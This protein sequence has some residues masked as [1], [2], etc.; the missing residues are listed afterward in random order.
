[1][2]LRSLSAALAAALLGLPPLPLLA[3]DAAPAA[4][5]AVT[6]SGEA[7]MP[8]LRDARL[9]DKFTVALADSQVVSTFTLG[10]NAAS[11]ALGGLI[12][13]DEGC[14]LTGTGSIVNPQDASQRLTRTQYSGGFEVAPDG[15]ADLSKVLLTYQSKSWFMALTATCGDQVYPLQG[16]MPWSEVPGGKDRTQCGP[17]SGLETWLAADVQ[18]CIR[19]TDRCRAAL[20]RGT[21]GGYSADTRQTHARAAC[22]LRAA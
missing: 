5:A 13:T 16:Q 9:H 1:M 12:A 6:L 17:C 8:S 2:K 14:R 18:D 11:S 3:E 21:R 22:R 7:V 15:A 19:P 10:C 4:A 20:S